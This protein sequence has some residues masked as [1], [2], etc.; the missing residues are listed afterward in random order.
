MYEYTIENR[1]TLELD[2][3]FGRDAKDAFRRANLLPFEWNVIYAEY[4]D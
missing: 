4:A 2:I 1:Q 3:I